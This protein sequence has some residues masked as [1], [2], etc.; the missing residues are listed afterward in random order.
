MSQRIIEG[1]VVEGINDPER[2][3]VHIR[4]IVLSNGRHINDAVMY[5]SDN[6]LIPGFLRIESQE[7]PEGIEAVDYIPYSM[8]EHFTIDREELMKTI[9]KCELR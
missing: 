6:S 4:E 3:R 8:I 7:V 2:H 9:L 1:Q 5:R